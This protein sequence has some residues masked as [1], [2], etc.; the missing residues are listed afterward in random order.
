MA[1]LIGFDTIWRKPEGG[2]TEEKR[3]KMIEK[4]YRVGNIPSL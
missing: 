2:S 4:Y 1:P 3:G